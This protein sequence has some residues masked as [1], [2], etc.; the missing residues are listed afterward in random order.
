MG[1]PAVRAATGPATGSSVRH[2]G[3]ASRIETGLALVNTR[4]LEEAG[5]VL[6][7]ALA[8]LYEEWQIISNSLVFQTDAQIHEFWMRRFQ[9]GRLFHDPLTTALLGT[10]YQPDGFRFLYWLSSHVV[11]PVFFGELLPIVLQPLAVWLVFRIVREQASWRPSAWI[12]GALFLVAWDIHRFSG[13]HPR[14]FA[15]PIVLL[16]VY[17]LLRKRNA[18][19]AL[20]PPLGVLLYPP[21]SLVALGVVLLASLD[22]RQRLLLDRTRAAWA[23]ASVVA[24]GIVTL[25][26]RVLSGSPGLITADEAR[27]FAEFG[28]N[29]QMRFFVDSSLAYLKQNYSGFLLESAGSLLAVSAL[30]LLVLRPRNAILLRWEVWCMP[31]A[32]LGLFGIAHA[33]LFLLYLPHRYTYSLLPFFCI[34][35]AV[36]L[37]PT[38]EAWMQRTRA[39]VAA[40][41]VLPV[42]FAL[43]ALT[44]FPLGPQRSLSGF[45]SWLTGAAG[46]LATGFAV[47]VIAAAALASR[48]RE[49]AAAVAA[50]ASA[51]VLGSLLVAETTFA[52]GGRNSSATTCRYPRLYEYVGTLP[53]NAIVAANP[54]NVHC[55]PIAARRAVVISR[56]LYQPWEESYFR[57]IRR[58]MFDSIA[59]FYGPSVKDVV[60]LRTRYGADYLLVHAVQEGPWPGMAPF[61]G[62]VRRLLRT[63]PES[64][65]ERLPIV[66]RTWRSPKFEVYSLACVE[67]VS[68]R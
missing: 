61:T 15:Q 23:T 34:V 2:H 40:A 49:G 5:V 29:G 47:G 37:R 56:K 66:C 4:W 67:T 54:R 26:V 27:G 43:V 11:D 46:Y 50:A 22:R 28:P 10:G 65:V 38:F 20:I 35:I 48:A 16:T 32:A 60:A 31:I 52:G 64:A 3:F 68:A 44:V 19:A 53:E 57:I 36:V 21:A 42:V 6:A 24:F 59:A 51:L 13:G 45:G 9:D 39:L 33:L 17:L 58:R 14:A 1:T 62:E 55:I 12:G 25:I 30:L 41:V 63:V 8:T 18:A 7:A